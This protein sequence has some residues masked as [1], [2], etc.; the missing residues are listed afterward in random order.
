MLTSVGLSV[1]HHQGKGHWWGLMPVSHRWFLQDRVVLFEFSGVVTFEEVVSALE[2]SASI[3]NESQGQSV[4][5][6]HDWS[7]LERFPTNIL[8]I[9][10]ETNAPIGDL[11]KLGWMV[12]YGAENRLLRYISQTVLQ[13]FKIRFRMFIRAE[14][15]IAYLRQMDPTLPEFALPNNEESAT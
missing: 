6:L 1:R 12:V 15:A 4:H 5:F 10:K 13:V 7:Q 3:V 2:T 8:Q 9:R 11:R 14:D